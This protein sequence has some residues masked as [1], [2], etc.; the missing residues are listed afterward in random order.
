[1]KLNF[2]VAGK[3]QPD[4]FIFEDNGKF[5]LYV[6]APRGVEAYEADDVFGVWHFKGVVMQVEGWVQYWAPSVIRIENTY[7]MYVSCQKK[8]CFQF[9]HVAK[10]TS[11]LGPFTDAK[12]LFDRFTIDSH[13]VKTDAG[14][15]LWYVEDNVNTDRIGTRIFVDRLIDPYTPAGLRREVIVPTMDEEI[16]K[17]NRYGDGKDWHTIEGPFWFREG[18]WQYVMYSGA[19]YENDTYHI[20]Y[21]AARSDEQDLTK[22]DFVKATKD[23][24][25]APVLFKNEVEEG[26]G[27]HS[28]IKLDGQYY[29]VYHGRDADAQGAV[30]RTARICKLHVKDGVITAE[31]M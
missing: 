29:A 28:V 30:P 25:F 9:M 15:F 7:Y 4:P 21:A 12:C 27:H 13:A 18:A 22:V 26:V 11:P 31:R 8:D 16:F 5:Y 3:G 19:C 14:L 17:R 10:A 24:K 6:T 20:G 23:G 2:D 1:M